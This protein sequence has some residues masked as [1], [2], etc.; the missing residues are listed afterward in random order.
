MHAPSGFDLHTKKCY[1]I[2]QHIFM[3]TTNGFQLA[4]SRNLHSKWCHIILAKL[5]KDLSFDGNHYN[6]VQVLITKRSAREHPFNL[7]GLSWFFGGKDN[8]V[9]QFDW[10]RIFCS[11]NGQLCLKY[12]FYGNKIMSSLSRKKY[13][14]AP[15]SENI[16][17]DSQKIRSIHFK[18]HR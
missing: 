13:S 6:Y 7:K 3:Y 16:Y 8:S 9:G 18:W 5:P 15:W 14:A 1:I 2:F 17:F 10:K 12:C 4:M 11:R